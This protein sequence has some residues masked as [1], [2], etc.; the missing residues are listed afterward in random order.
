VRRKSGRCANDRSIWGWPGVVCGVLSAG[1]IYRGAGHSGVARR[2]GIAAHV[3]GYTTT[4]AVETTYSPV[5]RLYPRRTE[6]ILYVLVQT[7]LEANCANTIVFAAFELPSEVRRSP[8]LASGRMG[9]EHHIACATTGG[10]A[11]TMAPAVG[12]VHARAGPCMISSW[13]KV[14]M[15]FVPECSSDITREHHDWQTE[16]VSWATR[17][18]RVREAPKLALH[19][20]CSW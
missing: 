4:D 1:V 8:A 9:R 6:H 14:A 3:E 11:D 13:Q 10:W 19:R 15:I 17:N 18:R 2:L 12:R 20:E 5:G 16:L 7:A